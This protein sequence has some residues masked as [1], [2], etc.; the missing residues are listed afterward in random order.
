MTGAEEV[1]TFRDLMRYMRRADTATKVRA[2]ILLGTLAGCVS[3][4][5]V[6]IGATIW[7]VS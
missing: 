4:L 7:L 3:V 5:A 2:A 1:Y 6:T